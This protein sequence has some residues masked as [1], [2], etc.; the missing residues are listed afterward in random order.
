METQEVVAEVED[1]EAADVVV[2]ES[3]S[4][5]QLEPVAMTTRAEVFLVQ[6]RVREQI[7][8]GGVIDVDVVES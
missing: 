1:G 7:V 8:D 6:V 3:V 4:G 5:V 2:A